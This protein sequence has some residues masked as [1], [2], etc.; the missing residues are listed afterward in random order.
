MEN[1]HVYIIYSVCRDRYYIGHTSDVRERLL[2]HNAGRTP[3]TKFGKPW[4][5]VYTETCKDKS[6]ATRRESEIKRMKSRLYLK[7]LI[8]GKSA[9]AGQSAPIDRG[10]RRIPD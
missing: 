6:T 7:T 10:G 1:Y 4:I 5:M 2:Q 9:S 8:N 3:S